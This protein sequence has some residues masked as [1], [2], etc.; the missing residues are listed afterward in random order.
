M[1]TVLKLGVLFLIV[2]AQILP[3]C[4]KKGDTVKVTLYNVLTDSSQQVHFY[5]EGTTDMTSDYTGYLFTFNTNGT[6]VVTRGA[7][8]FNGNWTLTTTSDTRLNIQFAGTGVEDVL[9]KLQRN[10]LVTDYSV[11]LIQLQN[12]DV[13]VGAHQIL[14]FAP[15]Q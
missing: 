8:T 1:K 5:E 10:W 9:L 12:D 4:S 7:L 14:H 3:A 2:A 15:K 11:S 6:L 13:G